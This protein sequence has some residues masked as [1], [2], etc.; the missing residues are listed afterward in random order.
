MN[1]C[2]T[3]H[4]C[5]YGDFDS[6]N[7]SVMGQSFCEHFFPL[8]ALIA[9]CFAL[10][11][12]RLLISYLK[13]LWKLLVWRHRANINRTRSEHW[14]FQ[15]KNKRKIIIIRWDRTKMKYQITILKHFFRLSSDWETNIGRIFVHFETKQMILSKL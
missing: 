8:L 13:R 2:Y 10:S 4:V 11:L 15:Q 3:L 7:Q 1:C 9:F 6:V 5:H 12:F 14:T